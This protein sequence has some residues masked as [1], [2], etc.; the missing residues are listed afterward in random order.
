MRPARTLA[1]RY[2]PYALVAGASEGIG[3]AF[4][5][6]L[7]AAGLHLVLV[8]RR[9]APLLALGAE[10][11]ESHGIDVTTVPCDLAGG[12]CHPCGLPGP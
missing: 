3:R 6:E 10:L 9:A 1:D 5:K 7:A 12:R 8:G 11:R 4:A 2:G